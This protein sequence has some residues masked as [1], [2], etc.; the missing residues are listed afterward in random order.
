MGPRA[1]DWWPDLLMW[2]LVLELMAL[3]VMACYRWLA[4][5]LGRKDPRDFFVIFHRVFW[6]ALRSPKLYP[7]PLNYD[8]APR[9]EK[10]KVLAASDCE[11]GLSEDELDQLLAGSGD[12]EPA[13]S[14]ASS[15]SPV[16]PSDDDAVPDAARFDVR[17]HGP[18]DADKL[19]NL[20]G[21][22]LAVTVT[23]APDDG[24][25]NSI[26]ISL[27]AKAFGVQTH[28]VAILSGQT[29]ADKVVRVSGV[30]PEKMAEIVE[31]LEQATGP[32]AFDED[33]P[34]AGDDYDE[35]DPGETGTFDTRPKGEFMKG[36]RSVGFRDD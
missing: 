7:L 31:I 25:A 36:E 8:S 35:P 20:V 1:F 3:A 32:T 2:A 17:V 9:R 19:C 18:Q 22:T 26:V 27:L 4:I 29:K 28:Q 24:R 11:A 12:D 23:T 33:D 16:E 5:A 21:R 30:S 14:P 13:A 10:K 34:F 6:R 15:Q